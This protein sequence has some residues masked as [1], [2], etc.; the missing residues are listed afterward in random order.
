MWISVPSNFSDVM[1]APSV[2]DFQ[3][4]YPNVVFRVLVTD[5]PVHR[6]EDGIDLALRVGELDDSSL[7]AG[8]LI[9]YR[10]LLVAS[11]E[12]LKRSK[13]IVYRV[14]RVGS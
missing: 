11:P 10:H 8:R 6:I 9:R 2:A 1:V 4:L 13:G 5:R 3:A 14:Y 12:H 7:V